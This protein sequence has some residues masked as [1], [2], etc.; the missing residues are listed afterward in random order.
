MR[1]VDPVF[2][3]GEIQAG[4]S[5]VFELEET[6]VERKKKLSVGECAGFSNENS[7]PTDKLRC[8]VNKFGSPQD[9]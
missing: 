7:S 2:K 9:G 4:R 3:R 8:T 5:V 1:D 6:N